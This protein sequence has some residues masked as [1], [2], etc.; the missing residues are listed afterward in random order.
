MAQHTTAMTG[1]KKLDDKA[2]ILLFFGICWLTY[3][4]TY[5]GRLN[6][7]A[8]MAEMIAAEGMSKA[9]LGMVGSGFFFGY[10]IGQLINGW[11][12]DR[13]NARRLVF[14]GIFTSSLMNLLMGFASS[15]H[16]MLLLWSINGIVQSSVWSPMLRLCSDLLTKAQCTKTCVNLATTV[17]IG[18][19]AAYLLATLAI[20]ASGWRMVFYS[21]GACLFFISALWLLGTGRL[22]KRAQR[23]GVLEEEAQ[24]DAQAQHNPTRAITCKVMLLASGIVWIGCAALLHGIVKDSVTTWAPTYL[25]ELFG[26]D[27]ITSILLTM[28]L[29]VVNLAGVYAA[30]FVNRRFVHNEMATSAVFFAVTLLALGAL[31]LFGRNSIGLS[32]ALL[33]VVTSA[34]LGINTLIV[35]LVPLRFQKLG[36]VSTMTGGLN[37]LTYLGSTI[38]SYGVGLIAQQQGWSI[39]QLCWLGLALMG[40]VSCIFAAYLWQRFCR[41]LD[42]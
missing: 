32:I 5:L 16:F 33:A 19:L 37:C 18:T 3:F 10:G 24:L 6:F 41:R 7:S 14:F 26:T 35:T 20:A 17:P 1:G 34:M 36:K 9:Q 30:T 29:P 21:S 11:L 8:A 42:T 13:L 27:A 4:G 31:I 39:V 2:G 38:S 22:E 40:I 28:V 15:Y 25:T 23:I 12:G